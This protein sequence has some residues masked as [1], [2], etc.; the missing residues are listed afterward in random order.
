MYEWAHPLSVTIAAHAAEILIKS[1]IA[2]EHPL[3]IF[4]SLPRDAGEQSSLDIERLFLSGRTVQFAELPD[5]LWATTGYHLPHVQ[6]YQDFGKLRNQIQH[7]AVPN[8]KL[9]DRTL[10]FIFL[11]LAPMAKDFWSVN[12]IECIEGVDPDGI[13]YVEERLEGLGLPFDK[14]EDS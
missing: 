9:A 13:E 10:S 14:V 5:L 12:V 1:R 3:L 4:S 7:F 11:V 6:E 8:V 2:E